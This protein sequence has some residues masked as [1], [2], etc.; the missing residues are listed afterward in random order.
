M[1][2]NSKKIIEILKRYSENVLELT[3]KDLLNKMK[4]RDAEVG[5]RGQ[6]SRQLYSSIYPLVVAT[7]TSVSVGVSMPEY[8]KFLDEGVKG[9]ESTYRESINSRYQ[10]RTKQ[11]PMK[12]FT[13]ATGWIAQKAIIDRGEVRK[14]TGKKGKALSR[15]VIAANKSLAFVIARSI[16]KKGI[17]AYSFTHNVL[18]N[19]DVLI[20]EL[21]DVYGEKILT[22]LIKG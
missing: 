11:P 3:K 17:K 10:F 8:G 1:N 21:T 12:P 16:R 19:A 13:G 2:L 9:S 6:M 18:D 4:Q 20:S 15:A 7:P 22:E 14:N 5:G